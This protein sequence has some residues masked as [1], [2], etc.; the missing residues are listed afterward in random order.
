MLKK[1]RRLLVI[2]TV[3]TM[4]LWVA[5]AAS[6]D[7]DHPGLTP[8]EVEVVVFPGQSVDIEKTVHLPEIPPDADVYFLVDTTGSMG[9]VINQI[10]AD[11]GL[12]IPAIQA[13][14]P[15]AQFGLGQYKDFPFDV[16]AFQQM[17]TLGP[18]DGVGGN[19]GDVS[20]TV[21]SL[22]A[23]GGFDGSEGQFFA[24][25]QLAEA[26]NPGGFN[27]ATASIIVWIGDAPAHD[28]VCSAISGL[29]YDITE[30]SVIAKL[31]APAWGG[32]GVAAVAISTTTGFPNALDDNPALSAGNYSPTCAVING[33]AGQATRIAGA[34]GGVHLANVPPADIAQ[35]ILDAIGDVQVEVSMTS[36]C[37]DPITTT[38]APA[39]QVKKSGEDAVFT[40]TIAVAADAP[41]G[42]YTCRDWALIDGVAMADEAGSIIYETK[43]VKVPEGFLTGGGQTG[44][45]KKA[46]NFGG[47]VGFL[48]DFSVVGQWQF[49]DGDLKLNMHSLDID[50]LQFSVDPGDP[51]D[52]PVANATV[53]D[54]SGTA[55]VKLGTAKWDDACTFRAQAHDHGEPDVADV[56][57]IQITCGGDVW[58]YGRLVLDTGNLQIHQG[59]KD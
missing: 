16:F 45:G 25:D 3:F 27:P 47:N 34:T 48:E 59:L 13:V 33:A 12:I 55:R 39:N 32:S 23:S 18:D 1:N 20:D 31:Q 24:L 46:L 14:A 15:T 29:G 2:L 41:G 17:V 6:A 10:K 30:A 4:A 40:E 26:G 58:T 53:A 7:G 52:P 19:P 11:I 56:F 49:R 9:S 36:D 28:P 43:T 8:D 51:P 38:F 44:K 57:G 5:P 22:F 21:G 37:V 35:A 42:T 54:F 50:Y